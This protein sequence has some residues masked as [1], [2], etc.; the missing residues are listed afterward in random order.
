MGNRSIA[1][2]DRNEAS[3]GRVERVGWNCGMRHPSVSYRDAS[4]RKDG[5]YGN[6]ESPHS[7]PPFSPVTILNPPT[8]GLQQKTFVDCSGLNVYLSVC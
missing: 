6:D 8:P 7:R 4:D 5:N 1:L 2:V 3:E